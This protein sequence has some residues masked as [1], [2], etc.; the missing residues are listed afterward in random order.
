MCA[1]H[2]YAKFLECHLLV[3]SKV[4]FHKELVSSTHNYTPGNIFHLE[5]G[6]TM[7]VRGMKSFVAPGERSFSFFQVENV[8]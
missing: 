8:P 6:E 5:E 1:L 4:I 7:L 2:F 3:F